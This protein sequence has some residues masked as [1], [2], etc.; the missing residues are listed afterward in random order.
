MRSLDG[1]PVPFQVDGDHV[2]DAEAVTFSVEPGAIQ[3]VS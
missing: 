2:G 1:R 3:V